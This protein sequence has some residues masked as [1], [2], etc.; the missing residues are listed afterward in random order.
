MWWHSLINH[1][2]PGNGKH[3]D[4]CRAKTTSVFPTKDGAKGKLASLSDP[5]S[6]NSL[7]SA[8][9]SGLST[10]HALPLALP[11]LAPPPASLS[12]NGSSPEGCA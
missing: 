7:I 11:Y 6:L 8:N 12:L 4:P 1:Y 9:S 10:S 5:L 3:N 2:S